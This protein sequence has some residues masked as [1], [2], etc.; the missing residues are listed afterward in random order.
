MVPPRAS[1]RSFSPTR[2]EPRIGSAPPRPGPVPRSGP[3]DANGMVRVSLQHNPLTASAALVWNGD[4]P[5]P[6]Q[7]MLFDA[8]DSL[9]EPASSR[10]A[11]LAS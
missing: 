8:A 7:Q 9:S 1:T 6:L 2:P 11:E 3:A 5:R 4:L 10:P